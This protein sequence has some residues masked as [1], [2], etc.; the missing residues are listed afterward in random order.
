MIYSQKLPG[1]IRK[2]TWYWKC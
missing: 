2:T 1:I